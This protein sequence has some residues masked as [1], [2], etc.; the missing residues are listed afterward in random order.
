MHPLHHWLG[1][2]KIQRQE[3]IEQLFAERWT[4]KH[5]YTRLVKVPG[6]WGVFASLGPHFHYAIFGRDSIETAE[7]ILLTHPQLA[8]DIIIAMCR[9]QGI[10]LQMISEEEPG[11]IHHEHRALHLNGFTIPAHSQQIM[12]DLQRLWGGQDSDELTYYG[13]YDATPLF[14]R[15]VGMYVARYGENILSETFRCR[16]GHI[17]AV[18]DSVLAALDWMVGKIMA[19]PLGLFAYKRLNPDG[20]ANQMWKDSSTSHLH[21]DGSLPN[22]EGSIASV[23]LQGYAYDAL[24]TGVILRLGT[25]KLQLLWR[26][27]AY[28]IQRQTLVSLWMENKQY[29][30]QGLDFDHRLQPRQIASVTSDPG[31]LLDSQLIHDLPASHSTRYIHGITERL[32]SQELLTGVGIRCRAV[33]DWD[34]LPFIDYHG[35]NTVWP[36]ETFDIAKGL[37]RGGMPYLATDLD[38]RIASSLQEAAE[39]SEFFYVSRDGKVWHDRE[40]TLKHFGAESPGHFLAVPEPGQAWTISAAIRISVSRSLHKKQQSPPTAFEQKI[41]KSMPNKL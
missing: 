8:R 2:T 32:F 19:H 4:S 40:S 15:L 36:K 26:D 13:S 33:E 3:V 16:S 37:R 41:L 38:R 12:H 11:K 18:R 23:A 31:V 34:L 7:D 24:R 28:H 14:V 17:S 35:T 5:D 10:Q 6:H 21:C 27:L 22:F 30:A 39:F 25:R 29:F 1:A 9:L 20:I